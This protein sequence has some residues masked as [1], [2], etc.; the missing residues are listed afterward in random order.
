MRL[1]PRP[2]CFTPV[3][4]SVK[5]NADDLLQ[6]PKPST[7][8]MM[9]MKMKKGLEVTATMT[10]MAHLRPSQPH[11]RSESQHQRQLQHRLCQ[12][13]MTTAQ[14]RH[15]PR[16]SLE[17]SLMTTMMRFLTSME[18][19]RMIQMLL[20]NP[21]PKLL[22]QSELC[23]VMVV[24]FFSLIIVQPVAWWAFVKQWCKQ[25]LSDFCLWW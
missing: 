3:S 10:S 19:M 7:H 22:P 15:H 13:M 4:F 9:T 16:E 20:L 5:A 1:M 21:S 18:Q 8:L 25:D 14:S 2:M 17:A 6:P 12:M 23:L 24:G 11:L